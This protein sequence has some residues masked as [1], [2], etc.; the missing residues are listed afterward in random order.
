VVNS[1]ASE[2]EG[3]GLRMLNEFR[4]FAVKG[5]MVDLA[6]GVIIGAAFGAIVTSLVGDIIMPIIGAITGGLDFSNYFT[7]LSKSV[8]ASNLADAKK[9]GAVLAWGSF[10]TLTLNFIIIAFVMFVVIRFMNRLKRRDEAAPP[11]KLT[12]QEELLTEIRDLLKSPDVRG[13]RP[14]DSAAGRK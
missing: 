13:L 4:E 3:K 6:V 11:P 7:P 12:R 10:L 8:T 9:Q 1:P 14:V 2:L 5:N